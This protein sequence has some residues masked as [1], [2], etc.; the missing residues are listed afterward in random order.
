MEEEWLVGKTGAALGH[1]RS[2]GLWLSLPGVVQSRVDADEEGASRRHDRLLNAYIF[3]SGVAVF[4]NIIFSHDTVH[5]F[6]RR[7]IVSL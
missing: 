1:I 6:T 5:I 4:T 3:I 7:F 2:L